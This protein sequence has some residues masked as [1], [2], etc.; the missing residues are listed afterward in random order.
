M[1]ADPT[2]WWHNFALPG[3]QSV[4]HKAWYDVKSKPAEM[5]NREWAAYRKREVRARKQLKRS[6]RSFAKN[7][8]IDGG[9]EIYLSE[10]PFYIQIRARKTN[11]GEHT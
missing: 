9:G 3:D 1:S 5:T 10:K 6:M 11:N 4:F 2:V 8:V 7:S